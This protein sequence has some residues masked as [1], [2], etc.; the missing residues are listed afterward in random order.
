MKHVIRITILI[1]GIACLALLYAATFVGADKAAG[2]VLTEQREVESG[3]AK[4]VRMN[5]DSINADINIHSGTEK[6]L[7]GIFSYTFKEWKPELQYDGDKGLLS[8]YQPSHRINNITG[9]TRNEWDIAINDNIPLELNIKSISGD[10]R[11]DLAKHHIIR[12]SSQTT[13]GDVRLD[14]SG[15]HRELSAIVIKSISGDISTHLN[16]CYSSLANTTLNSTSGD[17]S[18]DLS[19]KWENNAGITVS[20]ISGDM[21]I[22]IP[23]GIGVRVHAHT[24]SGDVNKNGLIAMD[25]DFVNPAYGKTKAILN[26]EAKTTS[27]DINIITAN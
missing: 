9:N 6:L 19:G 13:S 26:I 5:L 2:K 4:P 16:G 3:G 22:T 8:I 18:L 24:I 7:S 11:L 20:S 1:F 25:K 21:N 27:G 23:A 12:L 15:N 14:F 10:N 17:I